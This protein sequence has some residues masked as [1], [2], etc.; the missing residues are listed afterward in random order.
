MRS[1]ISRMCLEL[2]WGLSVI[3]T[4]GGRKGQECRSEVRQALIRSHYCVTLNDSLPLL[5]LGLPM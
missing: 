4:Q 5:G 3:T 1:T 2:N